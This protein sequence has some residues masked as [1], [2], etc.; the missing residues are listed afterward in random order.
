MKKFYPTLIFVFFVFSSYAQSTY[1]NGNIRTGTVTNSGVNAAAGTFWSEAQHEGSVAN[2][3]A[4]YSIIYNN[5]LTNN[6]KLADDFTVPSG[7]SWSVS[8]VSVYAYQTGAAATP[9]PF[10]VLRVQ[11]WN[12]VPEQSGS[13]VVFGDMTTNRLSSTVDSV[14]FRLFNTTTPA[15]GSAPGT[16]RRI[17]KLTA[18]ITGL[19]LN[20]GTYWLVWQLHATND[21][22]AFAP[23]ANVVGVR[24]LSTWNA[25]QANGTTWSDVVDGGNPATSPSVPQDFPFEVTYTATPLPVSFI[26]FNAF[27]NNQMVHLH[28]TTANETN[29]KGFYIERSS[30]G[31]DFSAL[32]FMESSAIRGNS[33]S[34]INYLYIDKQPLKGNNFYRLK[35][36]DVDG[37]TSYSNIISIN[38][39]KA[40]E[41]VLNQNFPN[42]VSDK[43]S[44]S[45]QLGKQSTVAIKIIDM[46][47][48][49]ITTMNKGILNGG[50]Y[51]NEVDVK[52]LHLKP[53]NY[54]YQL[55]VTPTDNSGTTT[56]QQTMLVQ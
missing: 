41:F 40:E 19:T 9:V 35:Q 13:T 52:N 22:S 21:G 38:L 49:T 7:Q 10:D 26:A 15:P 3:N 24:G 33:T 30:N 34:P 11:I 37:K 4:G 56:L 5:A 14:T 29:N 25:K 47:G 55:V 16:T 36:T 20:P 45:Y 17:W 2:T 43:T 51:I 6:F 27:K 48:R 12:G 32:D 46:N 18:N 23:P 44:I 53:G 50:I 39:N 31:R 8:S 1:K 28:W 42:P 54:I